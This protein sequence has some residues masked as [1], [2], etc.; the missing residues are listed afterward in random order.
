M[1][2]PYAKNSFKEGSL[3]LFL[4]LQTMNMQTMSML[5]NREKEEDDE[6]VHNQ[7]ISAARH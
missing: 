4:N 1:K 2:R 7:N 5:C 3:V 6:C